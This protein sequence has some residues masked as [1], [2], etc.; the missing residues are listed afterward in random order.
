M[1][2][3]EPYFSSKLIVQEV[4]GKGGKGVFAREPIRSGEKLIVWGG[5]PVT[6]AELEQIPPEKR[7]RLAVQV[8]EDLFLLTEGAPDPGDYIN[9]SCAPNAGL[10]RRETVVAMRDITPGEEICFDYAMS[11]GCAY[12][13]F[14]CACGAPECRGRVTGAD[15]RL[16]HLWQ[17]YA[18]YFSPYL[19][20]RIEQ[21]RCQDSH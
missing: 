9:H 21:L 6:L 15:W 2:V 13:E 1:Q 17:R 7:C 11:D 16:P 20:R 8:E 5:R 19:Q 14:E 10:S 12:D 18:G 3:S 4:P